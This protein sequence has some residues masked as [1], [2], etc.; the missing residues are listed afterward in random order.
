MQRYFG[1]ASSQLQVATGQ[2]AVAAEAL[3]CLGKLHT[4]QAKFGANDSKLDIAK[5]IVF[6]QAAIASDSS[7]FRS[8]NELGVLM[9]NSGRL[10][11]SQEMLKRSLQI[12]QLFTNARGK[13]TSLNW[14]NV[15]FSIHHAKPAQ[16]SCKTPFDGSIPRS[17]TK[18]HHWN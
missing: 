16:A 8:A 12:Q 13:R 6:H 7:N 3:Y 15:S 11:E 18:A 4:V 9:A 5:A 2:N 10:K 17:S 1:F 14:L